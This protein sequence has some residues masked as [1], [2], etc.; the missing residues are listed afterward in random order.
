MEAIERPG[1]VMA[2]DNSGATAPFS[3]THHS[4][5]YR[6]KVFYPAVTRPGLPIRWIYEV[7]H[8][9]GFSEWRRSIP[10]RPPGEGVILWTFDPPPA[11]DF[12]VSIDAATESGLHELPQAIAQGW[13][14]TAR[15]ASPVQDNGGALIQVVLRAASCSSSCGS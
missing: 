7:E 1:T 13:W 4:G 11:E 9:G 2:T 3:H 10:R 6:L 5:G 12:I 8:A 14:T 15:R